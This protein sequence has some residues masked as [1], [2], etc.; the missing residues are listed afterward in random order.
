MARSSLDR[1]DGGVA[2]VTGSSRGLGLLIARELGRQGCPVMLCAR[3]GD[4]LERA[5][6]MLREEGADVRS[7]VCDVNDA[8]AAQRLVKATEAAF[9]R[10][11]I[12]VNN[13]GVIQVGPLDAMT[14]ADF[15]DAMETMYFAPLRLVLAAVPGMRERGGGRIVTISSLGGRIPAPHLLPYVGAKFATAGL[16]Q[17]LRAELAADKISVTTVIPGLMRTGSHVAAEF[18]GQ[19]EREYAWFASAAGF[20]V[21]SMDGER[22]A[23]A[24]VR[25]AARRRP[26]LVLTPVGKVAVRLHGLAPATTTRALTVAARWLPVS[27]EE[28]EHN[29]PGRQAARSLGSAA[30]NRITALNDRAARRFNQPV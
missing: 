12:V 1:L 8:R 3:D 6:S 13:A 21:L 17:G 23:R 30:V 20:P 28:P 27:G 29:M 10:L 7:L 11:D 18:S 14:E 25:A 15:R 26:E 5:E 24:I 19:A 16:S 22:A 2:L 4:E 9:G